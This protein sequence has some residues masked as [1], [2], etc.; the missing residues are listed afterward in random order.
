MPAIEMQTC[1]FLWFFECTDF[2]RLI[3]CGTT[4]RCN[5]VGIGVALLEEMCLGLL[6]VPEDQDA[7][8]SALSL[9]LCLPIHLSPCQ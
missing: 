7:G 8:L 2:L 6:P 3:G 4:S 5:L 9:V 1:N